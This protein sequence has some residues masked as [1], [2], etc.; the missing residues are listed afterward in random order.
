VG[1]QWHPEREESELAGLIFKSFTEECVKRK[2]KI[3]G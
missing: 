2:E 3:R 1:I